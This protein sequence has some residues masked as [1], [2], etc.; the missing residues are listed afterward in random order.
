M[1]A[2]LH[3]HSEYSDGKLSVNNLI[4]LLKEKDISVFSITDHDGVRGTDEAIISAHENGMTA[5]PGIEFST[6]FNH[7]E[8]HILGYGIDYKS[9]LLSEYLKAIIF[10]R[11]YR[12]LEMLEKLNKIGCRISYDEVKEIFPGDIPLGRPHL[13]KVL[14][15]RGFVGSMNEAF[16][17]YIG[18]NKIADVKKKNPHSLEV[19]ELI[20][21]LGGMAF[22]AHPGKH[23][24][25]DDIE[26]FVDSGIDG[27]EVIHPTHTK[28]KSEFLVKYAEEKNLLKS[29]GSDFHGIFEKDFTNLGKYYI[30]ENEIQSLINL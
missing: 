15:D 29:G 7:R 28:A 14:V 6:E 23:F 19:I 2:D 20:K 8:V 21:E 24:L 4:N 18:D 16:C 27:I 13:A 26:D 5:I 17:K 9:S 3:I 30:D 10:S 12:F 22:L 1:K 11:H 25:W